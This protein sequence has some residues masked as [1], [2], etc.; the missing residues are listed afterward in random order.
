MTKYVHVRNNAQGTIAV[1]L[2]TKAYI[3]QLFNSHSN[4]AFIKIG[5][6]KLHPKDSFVKKVGREKSSDNMMFRVCE[7]SDVVIDG[8]R[9]VYYFE[10]HSDN[11]KISSCDL[12][13]A[14][15][16]ESDNVLLLGGN[17]YEAN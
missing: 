1:E 11:P 13:L 12:I 14:T 6:S 5:V 9:H 2:P 10:F 4:Q 17:I 15:T 16:A 8:T 3:E 7:I